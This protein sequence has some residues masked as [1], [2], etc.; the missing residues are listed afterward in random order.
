M[1]ENIDARVEQGKRPRRDTETAA[2]V[3]RRENGPLVSPS[4]S[5]SLERARF[6]VLF[7][8]QEKWI[9]VGVN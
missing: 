2:T 5:A 7:S 3:L 8:L 9:L 1:V 6:L 4:L